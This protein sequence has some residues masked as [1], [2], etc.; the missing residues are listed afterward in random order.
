MK[1]FAFSMFILLMLVSISAVAAQ[2][3]VTLRVMNWSAEQQAFYDEVIAEFE[4]EYPNINVEW[5]TLEQSAY[6]EALPLMFQSDDAPDVFF[7]LGSNRV[8]TMAELLELGWIQPLAPEGTDMTDW[9]TRWPEGSFAEGINMVNGVPYSF[10]FN[11][12]LIWGAGYM[13]MNVDVWE[14]AGLDVNDPPETRSELLEDCRTIV[15]ETGVFCMAVP[16]SG[17]QFQRTWYPLAGMAMTDQFFDIQTGRYAINDPRLLGTF[18]YIQQFFEE[19]LVVP[20][21]NDQTF[22]RAAFANGQAAVYF[23]GAWM[24][25]V[26]RSSFEF[27]NF[28]V[29]APPIPDDGRTGSLAQTYSENKYYVSSQT[30]HA[31]EAWLFV[32]FMTRPDG[33]FAR[34]YLARGFGTLAY[35]DNAAYIEDPVFL[36]I[37]DIVLEQNIRVLYP[38]PVVKCPTIITSQALI[39][40]E[41]IRRNWEFEE[42]S[43]ALSE[44]RDFAET[45]QEIAAEKNRVFL[46]TLEAEGFDPACY[47]FPEFDFTEAYDTSNY[48]S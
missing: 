11:D 31:E 21:F 42:M 16:L 8:L 20:G 7:W 18:D 25:S 30:A 17:N 26:F 44:G 13:Y 12:N 5:E 10:P 24:P 23:D 40:A 38:E 45:A 37:I 32:E 4:A 29:A 39:E 22:S 46:E 3:E 35:A 14:A 47:A 28:A 34:E 33:F 36:D 41:N 6:R 9:M 19:E 1:K 2:D 15:E 27:D 48:D 43:L